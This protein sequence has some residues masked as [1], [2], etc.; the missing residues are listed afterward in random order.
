VMDGSSLGLLSTCEI[1]LLSHGYSD[2]GGVAVK[3]RRT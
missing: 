3:P 1:E 2:A